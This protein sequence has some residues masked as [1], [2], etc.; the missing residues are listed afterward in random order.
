MNPITEGIITP[1]TLS[2]FQQESGFTIPVD[3]AQA[4][5]DFIIAQGE[6]ERR[7]LKRGR[8]LDAAANIWGYIEDITIQAKIIGTP[9][10]IALCVQ[11]ANALGQ[12]TGMEELTIG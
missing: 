5:I 2:Q 10:E 11:S 3:Q 6:L 4:L 7:Q 12:I 1:D 9:E 8:F